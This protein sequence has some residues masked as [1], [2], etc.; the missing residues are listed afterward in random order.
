M[1]ACFNRAG[2]SMDKADCPWD[3]IERLESAAGVEASFPARW[4]A[5]V[6]S[7]GRLIDLRHLPEAA[8]WLKAADDFDNGLRSAEELTALFKDAWPFARKVRDSLSAA[9]YGA[10]LIAMTSLGNRIAPFEASR[11][12]ERAWHFLNGC[13]A[14]G[15]SDE[16]LAR[17]LSE[18]FGAILPGG[19]S[20]A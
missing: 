17:L 18:H 8:A 3:I 4:T 13:E 7:C 19:P 11:W 14:A 16:R 6:R 20:A 2:C 9:D 12:Y 10:L 5:F 15:I 1:R